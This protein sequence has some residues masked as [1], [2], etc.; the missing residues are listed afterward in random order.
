M[1]FLF[2]SFHAFTFPVPVGIPDVHLSIF[3][4]FI[5]HALDGFVA[6]IVAIDQ[7]RYFA[8]L[9]H[10]LFLWSRFWI[11]AAATGKMRQPVGIWFLSGVSPLSCCCSLPGKS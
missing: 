6:D 8:F 4:Q 2:P 1:Q 11:A 7:E 9:G 3:G 10:C 5:Y